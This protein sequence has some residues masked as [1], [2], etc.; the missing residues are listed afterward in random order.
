MP[1]TCSVSKL[2]RQPKS[3]DMSHSEQSRAYT[4]EDLSKP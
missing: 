2:L 4:A 1:N 3:L